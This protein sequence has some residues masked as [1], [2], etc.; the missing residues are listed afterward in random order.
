M[1]PTSSRTVA[2]AGAVVVNSV[3]EEL[4]D[5]ALP[6]LQGRCS[7]SCHIFSLG[8]WLVDL[9]DAGVP[10]VLLV[11]GNDYFQNRLNCAEIFDCRN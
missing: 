3:L 9:N 2:A 1:C 7:V 4:V 10:R 8:K 11:F 6:Q 5:C